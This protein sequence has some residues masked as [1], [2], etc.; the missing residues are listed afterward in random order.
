[1][2]PALVVLLLALLPQAGQAAGQC[3]NGRRCSAGPSSAELMAELE[4]AEARASEY[5]KTKRIEAEED[6]DFLA[7]SLMQSKVIKRKGKLS[8]FKPPSDGESKL[9]SGPPPAFNPFKPDKTLMEAARNRQQG[10]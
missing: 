4:L 9:E 2:A 10:K 6:D 3:R 1:M 7:S 5:L 8:T